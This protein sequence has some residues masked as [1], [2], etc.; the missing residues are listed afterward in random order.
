MI[1]FTGFL[2]L[3]S[4]LIENPF[5]EKIL[6]IPENVIELNQWWRTLTYPIIIESIENIFLFF[7]TFLI[8]APKLEETYHSIMFPVVIILN[9]FLQ[10]IILSAIFFNENMIFNGMVGINFF[11]IT[12]FLFNNYKSNVVLFNRYTMPASFFVTFLVFFWLSAIFGKYVFFNEKNYLIQNLSMSSV[13]IIFGIF[14]FL[15][16]KFTKSKESNISSKKIKVDNPI[17]PQELLLT[18][19]AN[20]ELKK[21]NEKL[22]EVL[23]DKFKE[24]T[25]YYDENKLNQILDKI[26]LFGY[27]SLNQDEID[28]L[29]NYSKN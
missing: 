8:F 29:K 4:T 2:I 3:F 25:S 11:I 24:V 27:D 20:K 26:N 16:D 14:T 15:Q 17:N 28:F 21:V 6:L 9:I 12:N 7:I 23:D 13:G 19:I 18:T 10:G 22:K 5:K 1:L